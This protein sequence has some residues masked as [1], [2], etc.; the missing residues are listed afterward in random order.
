[1]LASQLGDR[2]SSVSPRYWKVRRPRSYQLDDCPAGVLHSGR[3]GGFGRL[4]EV[5]VRAGFYAELPWIR[6]DRG[7]EAGVRFLLDN[8]NLYGHTYDHV[9]DAVSRG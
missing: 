4:V 6:Q 2:A 5:A 8:M 9:D 7:R 3:V 1:M